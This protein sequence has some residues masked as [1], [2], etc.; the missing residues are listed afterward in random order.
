MLH[1]RDPRVDLPINPITAVPFLSSKNKS[2]FQVAM[3]VDN[4][5]PEF[6]NQSTEL[7]FLGL[8]LIS[9]LFFHKSSYLFQLCLL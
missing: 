3:P 9:L 5:F 7:L 6:N 1:I 4:E 8:S 2:R